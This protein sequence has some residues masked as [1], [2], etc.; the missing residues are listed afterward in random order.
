M[1]HFF[2]VSITDESTLDRLGNL[3]IANG[4][5]NHAY[6]DKTRVL[7]IDSDTLIEES[8]LRELIKVMGLNVTITKGAPLVIP[9]TRQTKSQSITRILL[10][11]MILLSS[12]AF[13]LGSKNNFVSIFGTIALMVHLYG[14]IIAINNITLGSI[15]IFNRLAVPL[16]VFMLLESLTVL[17][18]FLNQYRVALILLSMLIVIW[19]IH[20]NIKQQLFDKL[21]SGIDAKFIY[22]TWFVITI[23]GLIVTFI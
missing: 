9:I 4:W 7:E 18:L 20:Q 16:G 5:D 10:L 19:Y 8:K 11:V 12:I 14:Y 15:K 23:I 22:F 3:L 6:D 13:V 1:Q 2:T 21:L 17:L